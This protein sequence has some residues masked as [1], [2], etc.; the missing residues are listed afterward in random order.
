L[1]ENHLLEAGP[2]GTFFPCENWL[3]V[4]VESFLKISF[5]GGPRLSLLQTGLFRRVDETHASL[6]TNTSMLEALSSYTLF[7]CENLL[8]IAKGYFPQLRCFKVEIGYH[9]AREAYSTTLK[10]HM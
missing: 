6:H 4:S 1:K 10:K 8:R 2:S 7:P 9:W 5:Q 3:W